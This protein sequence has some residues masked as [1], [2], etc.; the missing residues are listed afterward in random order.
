MDPKTISPAEAGD[1]E[2]EW[3]E[4]EFRAR[5]LL[6][7]PDHQPNADGYT[8]ADMAVLD[9]INQGRRRPR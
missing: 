9:G 7:E 8:K 3:L 1:Q 5:G 2:I 4:A 6:K